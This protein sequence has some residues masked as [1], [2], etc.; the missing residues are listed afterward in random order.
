MHRTDADGHVANLFDDGT[1]GVTPGTLVEQDWLN[2]VQEELTHV[3]ET[4]G[5]TL[6]KGTNTQLLTALRDMLATF[7]KGVVITQATTN[8]NGLAATGNGTGK[9][10]TFA[11]GT[12]ATGGTRRDA[13]SITNGDLDMSG[14]ANPTSTTGLSNRLT[15]KNFAKAWSSFTGVGS[16]GSSTI[17]DGCNITSVV[18]ANNGG[19]G[20]ITVTFATAMAD[21][22]YA[23]MLGN[24]GSTAKPFIFS[25][26]TGSFKVRIASS[27]DGTSFNLASLANHRLD[28]VVFGAQ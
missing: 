6:V 17:H 18:E 19:A 16:A 3:I 21:T 11:A 23:V 9:G 1:P 12:A 15:P 13:V 2:A 14:V 26:S 22:N 25:K 4:L 27:I 5:V 24:N 7:T 20:E 28:V 8:G 10:G